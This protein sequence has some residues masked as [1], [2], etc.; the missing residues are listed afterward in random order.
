MKKW[1]IL[2]SDLFIEDLFEKLQLAKGSILIVGC[3][4]SE[5]QGKAIGKF[6]S[7]EIAER[8]W[9]GFSKKAQDRGIYLAFQCCEHLNRSLVVE[10]EVALQFRLREV[11]ARPVRDAGGSMA[12]TAWENMCCPTLVETIEGDGGVDIGQTL[13]GMHL[14]RVAV[15][16]RLSGLVYG[17]AIVSAA[18]T[19]FPLIGGKRAHYPEEE[20]TSIG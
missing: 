18:K 3:S 7:L 4:T 8:L 10:K 19:R 2:E 14:K 9:H 5:V 20:Q 15:P 11:S 1:D 13:I 17:S 6:G 12:T 16:V